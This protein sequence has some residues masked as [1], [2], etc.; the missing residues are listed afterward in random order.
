[1]KTKFFIVF[2]F[3]SM[4]FFIQSVKSEEQTVIDC[5]DWHKEK[6]CE[7]WSDPE[8]GIDD[9]NGCSVVKEKYVCQKRSNEY[10]T[11]KDIEILYYA[12]QDSIKDLI[13][14]LND[15]NRISQFE[16]VIRSV[17]RQEL[18]KYKK[19]MEKNLN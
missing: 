9:P 14:D 5:T 1:M 6:Y 7:V 15:P 2:Y 12:T 11:E 16:E 13:K 18:L 19:E 8:L 17:I 10:A 4:T 3:L